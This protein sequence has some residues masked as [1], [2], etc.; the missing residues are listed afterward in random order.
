MPNDSP[1]KYR[2]IRDFIEAVAS[3][4]LFGSR[5]TIMHA[6]PCFTLEMMEIVVFSIDPMMLSYND[7]ALTS[8]CSSG[9]TVTYRLPRRCLTML[10]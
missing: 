6:E 10:R 5:V 1:A 4:C 9:F 8:S 3:G 7:G 2:G